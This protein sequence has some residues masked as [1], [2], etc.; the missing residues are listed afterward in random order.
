M[1]VTTAEPRVRREFAG[2]VA[3]AAAVVPCRTH[4]SAIGCTPPGLGILSIRGYQ[5]VAGVPPESAPSRAS[6]R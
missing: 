5:R 1:D 2:Y 6:V 4:A 3:S